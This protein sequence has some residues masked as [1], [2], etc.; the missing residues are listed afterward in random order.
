LHIDLD[1]SAGI[2]STTVDYLSIPEL[3]DCSV[4]SLQLQNRGKI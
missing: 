2:F 1:H 3:V 4:L